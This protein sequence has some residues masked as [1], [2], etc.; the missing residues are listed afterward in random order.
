MSSPRRPIRDASGVGHARREDVLQIIAVGW[1]HQRAD[2]LVEGML[3]PF[4]GLH[5]GLDLLM[6]TMKEVYQYLLICLLYA[7]ICQR[8]C[9][10][11]YTHAS[12]CW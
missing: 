5:V 11:Y 2:I 10:L 12:R 6:F 4:I 3:L 7:H 1:C 8:T 9:S